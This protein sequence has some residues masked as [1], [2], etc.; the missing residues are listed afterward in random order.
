[1][2]EESAKA[3]SDGYF[4][5]IQQAN[6]ARRYPHQIPGNPKRPVTS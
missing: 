1:M 4:F 6:F 3:R 5:P 2:V